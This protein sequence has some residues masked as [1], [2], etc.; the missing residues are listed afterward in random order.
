M[1]NNTCIDYFNYYLK[2][3]LNDLIAIY[4]SF[5]NI[6]LENYRPLLENI[7]N[8]SDKY[9]KYFVT[10]INDYLPQIAKR[11]ES[12]FKDDE[13]IFIEGVRLGYLWNKSELTEK[14]K[15]AI[16][17][18]LQLLTLLGRRT[19]ISQD[20][21]KDMLT[22][23]GT[24]MEVLNKVDDTLNN[25]K[26]NDK[27]DNNGGILNGLMDGL[28]G[29]ND[30]EVNIMGEIMKGFGL[31]KIFEDFDFNE[32]TK[33]MED[34]FNQSEDTNTN[35][36][37]SCGDV[38]D[39]NNTEVSDS[40]SIEVQKQSDTDKKEV[41]KQNVFS[42]LTEDISKTFNIN[43]DD[44][45]DNPEDA[46]EKVKELL[47]GDGQ[48][49]LFNLMGKF[50]AKMQKQ[51]NQQ[52]MMAQYAAMM[53]QSDEHINNSGTNVSQIAEQ[54]AQSGQLTNAQKNRVTSGNRNQAARERLRAK[55]DKRREQENK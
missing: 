13:L 19:I 36:N 18:Y 49:K 1:M 11:D 12:I 33:N 43:P 53:R 42:E 46:M 35:F 26:D 39:D 7:D 4:P 8:G 55:L 32:F 10:K 41:P 45:D 21:L 20:E 15:S 28:T 22:K 29:E 27:S 9:V 51:G 48:K 54:L 52:E 17:K 30:G 50:T 40:G 2:E 25:D 6:I 34:V 24:S 38:S 44:K 5:K 3:F 37:D 23:I 16:W 31:G 47:S 14:N